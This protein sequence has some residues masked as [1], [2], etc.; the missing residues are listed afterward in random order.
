MLETWVWSLDWEDS[1]GE[2]NGYPLLYSGL[3]NP[4]EY[5]AMGSQWVGHNWVT[6]TSIHFR[7]L[8][9]VA[10]ILILQLMCK[11]HGCSTSSPAVAK[12]IICILLFFRLT[13]LINLIKSVYRKEINP[14]Y[15]LEE[16]VLM[17]KLQYFGHLM[18]R[19]GSLEKTLM[20]GKIEGKRRR[21]QQKMRWLDG[22]TD[23]IYMSLG[24]LQKIV[25][26]GEAW[27]CSS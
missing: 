2:G 1:P 17:L 21:G 16:L 18:Q 13:G 5:I 20:L 22:T 15:S 10:T 7:V 11:S 8:Q 14:E 12:L 4:M 25:K 6:F 3:E 9:S 24:K 23:S 19:S 27:C 26:D